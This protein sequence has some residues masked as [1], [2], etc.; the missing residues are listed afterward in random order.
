M[1]HTFNEQQFNIE[2]KQIRTN[3]EAKKKQKGEIKIDPITFT[4]LNI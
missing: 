1:V 4:I 3:K 2:E